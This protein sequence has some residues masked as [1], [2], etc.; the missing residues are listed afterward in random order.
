MTQIL[1]ETLNGNITTRIPY[2]FMRQAGRYLP[3]YRAERKISAGFMD[4]CYRPELA[5]K[6][7]MQPVKRFD[8]DAA[9][10]FSDILVIPDALGQKVNFV[11]GEGPK[12]DEF[13]PQLFRNASVEMMLKNLNPVYEALQVVREVLPS[14]KSL[15][16]FSGAPWTLACYMLEGKSSK[17]FENCRRSSIEQTKAFDALIGMLQQYVAQHLIK[18]VESGADVLQIFDSWAGITSVAQFRKYVIA[19]TKWIVAQVKKAHPNV[20]IIGFPKD[21]GLLYPDYASQTGVDGISI[22]FHTPLTILK[23]KIQIPMQGNLDPLVL[24]GDEVKVKEDV[25]HKLDVMRD[26]PFIFNLGHGIVPYT[27]ISNVEYLVGLIR[28]FKR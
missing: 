26:V 21:A 3:E 20:K 24:A 2:W 18:Q 9:I 22:D 23:D 1:L 19:P 28:D 14:E 4:M 8:M 25:A 13:S 6:V 7:T 12:L 5:A 16:G 11:T 17:N 10:I 27:P 15:I